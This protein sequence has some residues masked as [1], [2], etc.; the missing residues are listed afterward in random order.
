MRRESVYVCTYAG[1]DGD[2]VAH[3]RAWDDREAAE[4]FAREL[5]GRANAH[6]TLGRFWKGRSTYGVLREERLLVAYLSAIA[7]GPTR[8]VGRDMKEAHRGLGI[9]GDDWDVFR[10]ILKDTLE[11]LRIQERE[12]REVVD[13]A[14]SLRADI[15]QG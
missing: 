1:G 12:R 3:V 4:L 10:A 11:A 8:Y 7:G 9:T 6:P 15:I 13:F 14:E 5:F 2:L